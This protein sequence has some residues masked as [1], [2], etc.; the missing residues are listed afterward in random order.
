MCVC[1]LPTHRY[2]QHLNRKVALP[3]MVQTK[4]WNLLL[5]SVLT[6]T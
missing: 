4:L 5:C 1:S 2:P 3:R 6:L